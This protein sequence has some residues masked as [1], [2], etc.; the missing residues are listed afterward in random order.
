MRVKLKYIFEYTAIFLWGMEI[1]YGS[2]NN[3]KA[4]WACVGGIVICC[5]INMSLII[6]HSHKLKE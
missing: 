2:E 3:G 4:V 6:L 5:I 1:A